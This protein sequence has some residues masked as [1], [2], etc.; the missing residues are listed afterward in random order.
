MQE[1]LCG[2]DGIITR[3]NKALL[4]HS[5]DAEMDFRGRS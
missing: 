4:E 1:D 5:L 3:I 2:K